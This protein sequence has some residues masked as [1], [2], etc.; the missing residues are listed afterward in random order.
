MSLEL[1]DDEASALDDPDAPLEPLVKPRVTN[2]VGIDGSQG[3][4]GR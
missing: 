2:V 4:R 3:V 1:T